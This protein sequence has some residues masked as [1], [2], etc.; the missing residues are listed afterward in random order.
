M[1]RRK[2][3]EEADNPQ[4]CKNNTY[5]EGHFDRHRTFSHHAEIAG[6]GHDPVRLEYR[7]PYVLTYSRVI[8]IAR[9]LGGG[10]GTLHET[11]ETELAKQSPILNIAP[12]QAPKA[13]F[14]A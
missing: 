14:A 6:R 5:L 8:S 13:R 1:P 11:L 9:G 2:A 4:S 3:A 12:L 10:F 7:L